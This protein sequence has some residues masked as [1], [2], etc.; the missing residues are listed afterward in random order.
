MER[1]KRQEEFNILATVEG[2]APLYRDHEAL[3]DAM[4]TGKLSDSEKKEFDL[5]AARDWETWFFMG[6]IACIEAPEG[7]EVF[8]QGK[9][10]ILN[11]VERAY[12]DA[13]DP[14]HTQYWYNY[15]DYALGSLPRLHGLR[16]EYRQQVNVMRGCVQT[17]SSDMESLY[18]EL[19]EIEKNLDD[20]PPP[21]S[22]PGLG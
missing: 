11:S 15:V 7:S 1:D 9:A 17:A 20:P 18:A 13:P 4:R 16:E 6:L 3:I 8:E 2:M 21:P 14:E 22:P 5:I 10:G 12:V 19:N